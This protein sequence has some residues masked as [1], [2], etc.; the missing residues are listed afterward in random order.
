MSKGIFEQKEIGNISITLKRNIPLIQLKLK[1]KLHYFLLDS[2]ASNS[3]LDEK[4]NII[5]NEP[6]LDYDELIAGFGDIRKVNIYELPLF[7][8]DVMVFQKF[9][10]APLEIAEYIEESTGIRI[11]GVIGI[12]F[13]YSYKA[14]IDFY[15]LSIKLTIER[16]LNKKQNEHNKEI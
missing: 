8:D 2:G 3:V 14:V 4:A 6:V 9:V 10:V 16:E 15:N 1:G 11:S 12:D 13:M 7:I 5:T